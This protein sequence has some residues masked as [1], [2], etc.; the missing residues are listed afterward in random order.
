MQ[1][2]GPIVRQM[3]IEGVPARDLPS[4]MTNAE[5]VVVGS[6]AD[7][8]FHV[9][10]PGSVAE[11]VVVKARRPIVVVTARA[12]GGATSGLD[13]APEQTTKESDVDA[14]LLLDGQS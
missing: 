9:S 8:G 13:D 11:A 10:T 5:L 2:A 14:L 12:T 6:R 7:G 1:R 3:L 4:T